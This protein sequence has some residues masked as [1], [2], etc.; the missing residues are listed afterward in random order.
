MEIHP[1][2]PGNTANAKTL[3]RRERKGLLVRLPLHSP[4]LINANIF[5]VFT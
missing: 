3:R 4:T 1:A 2:K 5:Y